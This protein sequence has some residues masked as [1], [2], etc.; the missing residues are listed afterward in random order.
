M[1]PHQ[2]DHDSGLTTTLLSEQASEP[3]S[4]QL[5]RKQQFQ[6][7][8]YVHPYKDL[9]GLGLSPLALGV[10]VICE[11]IPG[12]SEPE[13]TQ[14]VCVHV[15]VPLCV[16]DI[17]TLIHNWQIF[18][19]LWLSRKNSGKK[20]LTFLLVSKLPPNSGWFSWFWAPSQL[21]RSLGWKSALTVFSPFVS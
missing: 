18:W 13:R 21:L 19:S 1:L 7:C 10:T 4:C 8:A 12:L 6:S 5:Q 2:W 15:C 20:S 3:L 11:L 16:C 17:Y 14:C 9:G